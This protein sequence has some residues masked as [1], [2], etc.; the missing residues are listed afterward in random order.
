M[1]PPV[2]QN[3]FVL[4]ARETAH[5]VDLLALLFKR[6][7]NNTQVRAISEVVFDGYRIDNSRRSEANASAMMQGLWKTG[8]IY[9]LISQGGRT[10][11]E[12]WDALTIAHNLADTP[13]LEKSFDDAFDHALRK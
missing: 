8:R 5:N 4:D 6:Y 11:A 7:L 1:P 3:R 10:L 12:E 9:Y 2:S 13:G